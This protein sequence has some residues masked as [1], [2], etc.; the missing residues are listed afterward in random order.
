MCLYEYNNPARNVE[1]FVVAVDLYPITH[2]SFPTPGQLLSREV[3]WLMD[4]SNT[5][6][7]QFSDRSQSGYGLIQGIKFEHPIPSR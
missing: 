3:G 5:T 4:S 6:V 1:F 2:T 7:K